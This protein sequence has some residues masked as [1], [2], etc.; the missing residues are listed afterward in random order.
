MAYNNSYTAVTGGTLSAAQWNTYVRD[1]F[2][3]LW[4]YTTA[5]DIVYA[6]SAIALARLAPP[7]V[8]GLLSYD[9]SATAP[10]W[11]TAS[12]ANALKYLRQNS[13]GNGFEW[14]AGGIKIEAFSDNN[15]SNYSSASWRD[16]PN[17]SKSVTVDVTSTIVVFG[18]IINY[19][20]DTYGQRD[21]MVNI[22]GYDDSGRLSKE[23]Y[24][25]GE[26]VTTMVAGIKTGVLAGS[27]TVKLREYVH[28]GTE[29]ISSKWYI[30]LIVPE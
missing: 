8:D 13:T 7:S 5:G 10:A 27:R 3:A 9:Y 14:A 28:A 6:T 1:N 24:Q 22:D 16:I 21:F 26:Y 19:G 12:A 23:Y 15:A 17:S 2:T 20:D 29:H 25:I 4:V 18:A 30:I 11:M